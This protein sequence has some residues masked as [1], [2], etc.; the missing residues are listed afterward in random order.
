[1]HVSEKLL[2]IGGY[3]GYGDAIRRIDVYDI[4][5]GKWPEDADVYLSE[6]D[7]DHGVIVVPNYV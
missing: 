1:M 5:S 7:N 3:A 2:A 6:Q 4:E